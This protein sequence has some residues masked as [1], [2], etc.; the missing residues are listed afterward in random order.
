MAL[1]EGFNIEQARWQTWVVV[2]C[3][4]HTND[5]LPAITAMQLMVRAA[6][7]GVHITLDEAQN[8]ADKYD[9]Y[10]RVPRSKRQEA[11]C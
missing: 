1:P 6:D 5:P 7:I 8:L 2:K 11:A 9:A 10:I 4:D 3:L